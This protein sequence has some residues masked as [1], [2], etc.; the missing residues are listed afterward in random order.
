MSVIIN[1]NQYLYSFPSNYQGNVMGSFISLFQSK[2]YTYYS[3]FASLTLSEIADTISELSAPDDTPYEYFAEMLQ[4]YNTSA[5]G[6]TDDDK[7]KSYIAAIGQEFPVTGITKMVAELR[8]APFNYSWSAFAAGDGDIIL[9]HFEE[10]PDTRKQIFEDFAVMLYRKVRETE[11][12]WVALEIS[13]Q[14]DQ[15]EQAAFTEFSYFLQ[16]LPVFQDFDYF[17]TITAEQLAQYFRSFIKHHND[18]RRYADF[19]AN[20]IQS[21]AQLLVRQN[22]SPGVAESLY[23]SGFR[24]TLRNG[25][26]SFI[27]HLK[28]R[29]IIANVL[30]IAN[31]PPL[32]GIYD[33]WTC[34]GDDA[35]PG[36]EILLN[37]DFKLSQGGWYNSG[38]VLLTNLKENSG[39]NVYPYTGQIIKADKRYKISFNALSIASGTTIKDDDSNVLY[40]AGSTGRHSFYYT[41]TEDTRLKFE[42]SLFDDV[43]IIQV[44]V[45]TSCEMV[46]LEQAATS[47]LPQISHIRTDLGTVSTGDIYMVRLNK[48]SPLFC[49]TTSGTGAN[50]ANVITAAINAAATSDIGS[51]T[52]VTATD[53]T[54]YVA[55]TG[56]ENDKPFE[57][58]VIALKKELLSLPVD[59]A[60]YRSIAA[61]ILE[62]IKAISISSTHFSYNFNALLT[63]STSG[64]PLPN[65]QVR[66]YLVQGSDITLLGKQ[67]TAS[68]GF[69]SFVYHVPKPF[70]AYSAI[71][72]EVID[73]RTV[74]MDTT[75]GI[76]NGS[77]SI[78]T[79]SYAVPAVSI[80]YPTIASVAT[81]I[82]L[83]IPSELSTFLSAN[84]IVTL[85]DIRDA[86]GLKYMTGLPV[87][88]D[89]AAVVALDAHAGLNTISFDVATNQHMISQGY[90]SIYEMGTSSRTN[91][92]NTFMGASP[93]GF[94]ALKFQNLSKALTA[95][96]QNQIIAHR[97]SGNI[98]SAL[99]KIPELDAVLEEK[100]ICDD[101]NAAVSPLAY[102][103]DLLHYTIKNTK[104][105][106][107]GTVGQ[108]SLSFLESN[109][110]QN[111]E[112]LA[113]SC[114][115]VEIQICQQRVV[116]EILR[117]Y[118]TVY[119]PDTPAQTLLN[120]KVKA[121]CINVYRFILSQ[122]G[123]SYEELRQIRTGT[124]VAEKKEK[125]AKRLKIPYSETS[126]PFTSLFVDIKSSNLTE[127]FLENMF[128]LV[129][130]TRL[131][132]CDGLKLGDG[133][134]Q[135]SRWHFKGIQWSKNT[136]KN[137]YLYAEVVN[138][139]P[140]VKLYKNSARGSGDLV[141]TATQHASGKFVITANNESGLS[142]EIYLA[143]T[144]NNT[145]V[146]FSV[147]PQMTAWKL[148]YLRTSWLSQDYKENSYKA[149]TIPIIEPDIIGPDDFRRPTVENDQ[150]LV[151]TNRR[152]WVDTF[153]ANLR[154]FG[155]NL[156]AMLE[157]MEENVS[158][159]KFDTSVVSHDIWDAVPTDTELK[160]YYDHLKNGT[161]V[162]YEAAL[163]VITDDLKLTVTSYFRLYEL[164]AAAKVNDEKGIQHDLV[165]PHTTLQKQIDHIAPVGVKRGDRFEL[166]I[167]VSSTS[168]TISYTAEEDDTVNDVVTELTTLINAG[169]GQWNNVEADGTSGTYVEIEEKDAADTAFAITYKVFRAPF[170][171][172][173][174]EIISILAQST[175][176]T[177]YQDWINEE[178]LPALGITLN[179]ASFWNPIAEPVIGTWPVIETAGVPLVDPELKPIK[180]LP[181]YTVGSAAVGLWYDR[182]EE[183]SG[184]YE[185]LRIARETEGLEAAYAIAW[186]ESYL[187]SYL[188]L[189]ELLIGL[190]DIS[191][192][193]AMETARAHIETTLFLTEE[194]FRQL[195]LVHEKNVAS[196]GE[197]VSKDEWKGVYNLLTTA[198]KKQF[199]Y[200]DWSTAEGSLDYWELCKAKLPLWRAS[201]EDRS[202]WRKALDLVRKKPFVDPDII[203]PDF[204]KSLDSDST[205]FALWDERNE[206]LLTLF[207]TIKTERE[208]QSTALSGFDFIVDKYLVKTTASAVLIGLNEQLSLGED[209][210]GQLL[211][212]NLTPEALKFLLDIRTLANEAPSSILAD[213]WYEVYSILLQVD[214]ERTFSAWNDEEEV[215]GLVLS[216]DHFV[217]SEYKNDD[218][219]GEDRMHQVLWRY[220]EKTKKQWINALEA[221][222]AQETAVYD[223]LKE[224]V[225]RAEE[226]WMKTLRDALIMATDVSG[227]KLKEKAKAVSDKLM[228]DAENNCCQKTTRIAQAIE[229]LQGLFF[230]VRT[231]ILQDT[232]PGLTINLTTDR[233]DE[234]WVWMGSYATWRAAMFV[235]IYPENLL[236]PTYR[237]N[238][239]V[240]FR[241]F[242]DAIRNDNRLNPQKALKLVKDYFSYFEDV[243][244]L[245]LV[246]SCSGRMVSFNGSTG[247][248]SQTEF[249]KNY[250]YLFAMGGA[251]GR[252][253]WSTLDVDSANEYSEYGHSSWTPLEAFDKVNVKSVM[254][255]TAWKK[256][257]NEHFLLF[258]A[259]I[260]K[261]DVEKIGYAKLNLDTGTWDSEIVELEIE[262]ED[263][264]IFTTAVLNVENELEAP[265]EIYVA[266]LIGG[267]LIVR[268][269]NKKGSDLVNISY[270]N[271]SYR[272]TKPSTPVASSGLGVD[273]TSYKI[274]NLYAF[275]NGKIVYDKTARKLLGYR[276][277]SRTIRNVILKDNT[278]SSVTLD[279]SD[280]QRAVATIRT[281]YL[282]GEISANGHFPFETPLPIFYYEIDAEVQQEPIY[283]EDGIRALYMNDKLLS[284]ISYQEYVASFIWPDNDF[285]TD[286]NYF[287][288]LY[289]QNKNSKLISYKH[290]RYN[291]A[292]VDNKV[293]DFVS[294]L[295]YASTF[296]DSHGKVFLLYQQ[297]A[298]GSSICSIALLRDNNYAIQTSNTEIVWK[299]NPEANGFNV[300]D[301]MKPGTAAG[302]KDLIR[303]NYEKNKDLPRAESEYLQ[304]AYYFV[305][306]L[307]ALCLQD[308]G[309]YEK[310]LD[311]F[312]TVYDYSI[313]IASVGTNIR[314]RKIWHGLIDEEN[315]AGDY[316]RID[317]WLSDPLNP[318][319]LAETRQNLYSRYTVLSI[320]QCMLAFADNEYTEDTAESVPR[321]RYMYEEALELLR[322]EGLRSPEADCSV[323]IEALEFEPTDEP[324][325]PEWKAVWLGIKADL[326]RLK[327]KTTITE[328]IDDIND[329]LATEHTLSEKMSICRDLVDDALEQPEL[330]TNV[331]ALLNDQQTK[332]KDASMRLMKNPQL[333]FAAANIG[334][335]LSKAFINSASLVTGLPKET[336]ERKDFSLSWVH[337][338]K[339]LVTSQAAPNTYTGVTAAYPLKTNPDT[340]N[341]IYY[342]YVAP[343][344]EQILTLTVINDPL[345]V[346]LAHYDKSMYYVPTP[347]IAFCIPPNPV[348]AGLALQAELNLYKLRNCMNIA[349]MIRELDPYAAP[350][351]QTTGLPQVGGDGTLNLNIPKRF[352]PSPHRFEV[353]IE[354]ARQQVQMAQ[355]L[356]S[357]LLS[358]FE[359]ADAERYSM[360]KARQDLGLAK[361]GVRLQDLK[362]KVAES[363][364]TLAMMQKERVKFVQDHYKILIN[365][366]LLGSETASLVLLRITAT[367]QQMAAGLN[368]AGGIASSII[369]H[370]NG[371][372]E[373][374][375]GAALSG[376]AQGLSSTASG[377]ST[378]SQ[379]QS[380]LASFERR[381]QEWQF[382]VDLGNVDLKISDQQIRIAGQQRDVAQQ[383]RQI[384]QLQVDNAEA[385]ISFLQ[386]KFT[387]VEL[388]DWMAK[389]ISRAYSYFLQQATSTAQVAMNQLA[390]ERQENIPPFIRNDYWEAPSDSGTLSLTGGGGPDRQGLTGSV[391]LLQDIAR[392]DQFAFETDKRKLQLTKTISLASL[393]P[394]SFHNFRQTGK[395]P[396]TTT[397][398]LFDKDFPGHYLRLIKRIKVTVIGLIPPVEGIK[399][400]LSNTGLSYAITKNGVLFERSVIRRDPES[401]SFTS[402]IEATGVF[403]LNQISTK[404]NPFESIGVDTTW[405]LSLPKAA[406]FFDYDTIADVLFTI[407]YTAL[408]SVDYRTILLKDMEPEID[409]VR[410]FN[411]TSQFADQWY[412]LN[413]PVT[414][415]T[416]VTVN[417]ETTLADFPPNLTDIGIT[418]ATLFFIPADKTDIGEVDNEVVD[419]LFTYDGK[420]ET[421]MDDEP[422][423]N[424]IIDMASSFI[425]TPEGSWSLVLPEKVVRKIISKEIS[426][427]LFVI[428]YK[429]TTPEWE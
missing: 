88:Q 217:I 397:S 22:V 184:K 85:E 117:R 163:E 122:L 212:L 314:P 3:Q 345:K 400:S 260:L 149:H 178:N 70:Q 355:Q 166:T 419:L 135:Y 91:V 410:A 37:G 118:L 259:V 72:I 92:V 114:E 402:A 303:T 213:E 258:F 257:D 420:E 329:E 305:P 100:C 48:I 232:Y 12:A 106:A 190:N 264:D 306:M 195:M 300:S 59:H 240:G 197:S 334:H 158:Y 287:Y 384:S 180:E 87:A 134:S 335:K 73:G 326:I 207:N 429:A 425:E 121:Y 301:G 145:T 7:W 28:A 165:L 349:G 98:S 378:S 375:P 90:K 227:T 233:F 132:T 399:A 379:I 428:K 285:K 364:I 307:T 340:K 332:M 356:E 29:N 405:E 280:I 31:V 341:K 251:T 191:N 116:V 252:Y 315:R 284:D 380:L 362:L 173:L 124:N 16:G 277:I 377:L 276:T 99:G 367:L 273:I 214:K 102:L 155:T 411:F 215:A 388:Y 231:G 236:Y 230:S 109:F 265:K 125:L 222:I 238:Q 385:T 208:A 381:Q 167:T 274:D 66:G 211:Q 75:I 312:R 144:T 401:V 286:N 126:D 138:S 383:E 311:W 302:W 141:G 67:T 408:E 1:W 160:Q 80:N 81:S 281:K 43:S 147:I 189:D 159:T 112:E 140:L 357:T 62:R 39:T 196:N 395:F 423:V 248:A 69:F 323:N 421:I 23:L 351:D 60:F 93:G 331:S 110:F 186:G 374:N 47:S 343:T 169:T 171:E 198:Y 220:S 322:E 188:S 267:K 407:E 174:E 346:V 204:L 83:T 185:L 11:N 339:K 41:A 42:I 170:K 293:Y 38:G 319:A 309:Y 361:A 416:P 56:T 146:Y 101:C 272:E 234:E 348:L 68:N 74:L 127:A 427:I 266:L 219:S 372:V 94:N 8:A 2:G 176:K 330:F 358:L 393:D 151:W 424:N 245:T 203:R 370:N 223:L 373:F 278:A 36:H 130:T 96:M 413:N 14:D 292:A 268:A 200:D 15:Q 246:A 360:L 390:F 177:F 239:T 404:L 249:Y 53:N 89:H 263:S 49:K 398:K 396:F 24:P 6:S 392:L 202:T 25:I 247:G 179:S 324:E 347:N 296:T 226:E 21:R 244:K 40:T 409:A 210:S 275:V 321:A 148:Q 297:A 86:G 120:E 20:E 201:A 317:S 55:V 152:R 175:K 82:S 333:N 161:E 209:I 406:N 162:Q 133:S 30:G 131:H 359:K 172:E 84:S 386:N 108:L 10:Y 412:D 261:E 417:F 107:S 225:D 113:A 181:E 205:A 79:V 218:F 387:N 34:S 389:I 168:T 318:H 58:E 164:Y 354:R 304:E 103:T 344:K 123:T 78:N 290:Y 52:V 221:R 32:K 426:D 313:P 270:I 17:K 353:I 44:P 193:L 376:I 288:H 229:T 243:C 192:P 77:E 119:T 363:N 369:A 262:K 206:A 368:V 328:V 250:Q 137:G 294:D 337:Q 105:A 194:Q 325:W 35:D 50:L 199:L 27:E 19:I 316:K 128:G 255:A 422:I 18:P 150:F 310:A 65:Y 241:I 291:A 298:T 26:R 61:D 350:T 394:I 327:D 97:A 139:G 129:S 153:L 235:N 371:D 54:T 46:E 182:Q 342:N 366:G 111:F 338:D 4:D 320:V 9:D 382:Q 391:R 403:E 242:A 237:K 154:T 33:S 5:G 224:I 187:G 279:A 299:F 136:D 13:F 63:D 71:K 283:E 51:W 95:F 45:G 156:T 365:Q 254:G 308:K 352:T 336:L 76:Q 415:N 289:K 228:I 253:Y 256:S 269:L 282:A 64:K 271:I 295:K 143:S 418:G 57:L 157:E 142:G 115:D 183:L 104:S 414:T 216:P